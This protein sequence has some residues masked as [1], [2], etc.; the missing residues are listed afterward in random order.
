M[1]YNEFKLVQEMILSFMNMIIDMI[2]LNI[3]NIKF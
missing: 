2:S 3:N 1:T